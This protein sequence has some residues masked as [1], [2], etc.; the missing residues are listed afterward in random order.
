MLLIN[1]TQIASSDMEQFLSIS[2]VL[3]LASLLPFVAASFSFE[4]QL[5]S[6]STRGNC[7][8]DDLSA[9]CETYLAIF[10]LRSGPRFDESTSTTDC[11]LGASGR[12][13]PDGNLP[14]TRVIPSTSPWTVSYIQR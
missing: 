8:G 5:Q 6:V 14:I 3:A 2:A 4:F 1:F 11:S 7:L 12:F 9:G 13:G 10:C